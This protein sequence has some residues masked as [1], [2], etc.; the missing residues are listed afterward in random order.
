MK[1]FISALGLFTSV[2][3]LGL[4]F[5]AIKGLIWPDTDI[6]NVRS[7]KTDGEEFI[8]TYKVRFIPDRVIGTFWTDFYISDAGK[9]VFD[10][11]EDYANDKIYYRV[12]D[13]SFVKE[14]ALVAKYSWWQA[15]GMYVVLSL[16]VILSLLGETLWHFI[17]FIMDELS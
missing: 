17:F 16:G 12:L 14:Y 13:D 3:L 8:T 1:N 10:F 2:L 6:C 15:N 4:A 9:Y 7:G 5:S 11:S